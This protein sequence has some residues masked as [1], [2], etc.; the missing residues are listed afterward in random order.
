MG[1]RFQGGNMREL[2]FASVAFLALTACASTSVTPIARNQLLIS[3]SAAPACGRSGAIEVA[4]KMAA[5]ETIRR[6]FQRYM[7]VAATNSNNVSVHQS[8]PTYSH[9]QANTTLYG[10]SVYG[11]ATTHYGGQQTIIS[12]THDTDLGVIMFNP[13]EPGFNSG[14]DAKSSL[15]S[16]WQKLVKEGIKTCS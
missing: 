9:T 8:G 2:L 15:G 3:T 4:N 5:V 16:E 14:I 6:G 10:N 7:I 12:G 11:N 13:G 1:V